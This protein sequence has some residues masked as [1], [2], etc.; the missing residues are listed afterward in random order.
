M[1]DILRKARAFVYLSM[2]NEVSASCKSADIACALAFE[3][4]FPR[5]FFGSLAQEQYLE[6][7]R[8]ALS[9]VMQLLSLTRALWTLPRYWL[10]YVP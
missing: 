10:I 3:P 2:I 6:M 4:M 8:T 1:V 9:P 5:Y 7:I